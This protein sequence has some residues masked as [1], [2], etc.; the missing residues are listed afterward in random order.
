MAQ[1]ITILKP[2]QRLKNLDSRKKLSCSARP[3]ELFW[4]FLVG[5]FAGFLMEG[6]WSFVSLGHWENHVATLWGPFCIVY[7]IGAV[8]VYVLSDLT[9][10]KSVFFQFLVYVFAGGLTEYFVSFFQEKWFGSVSWDYSTQPLNINGRVSVM[11]ALI[12]GLIGIFFAKFI[13]SSLKKVLKKLNSKKINIITI[14]VAVFMAFN[15]AFT[16]LAVNRWN[17]REKNIAPQNTVDIFLDTHY[18]NN[19]MESIFTNLNFKQN[20]DF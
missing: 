1:N 5:S 12:W 4:I 6:I 17:N 16:S 14:L 7:G 15:L 19:K 11:M 9:K 10:N 2:T 20:K 18:N 13:F 3:I 8:L